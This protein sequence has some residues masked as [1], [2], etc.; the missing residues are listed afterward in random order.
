MTDEDVLVDAEVSNAPVAEW[1]VTF[2]DPDFNLYCDGVW[3]AQ[4]H[5]SIISRPTN[6]GLEIWLVGH[7]RHAVKVT[8]SKPKG[9]KVRSL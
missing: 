9:Y 6:A 2:N 3:R 4:A 7:F 8:G 1:S 5:K